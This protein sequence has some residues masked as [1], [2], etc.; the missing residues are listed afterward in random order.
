MPIA[1]AILLAAC[2]SPSEPSMNRADPAFL[3][4]YAATWRFQLGR[5][6]AITVSPDGATALFLRSGPRSFVQDLWELN[7]ATGVA[8]VRLTADALLGGAEETLTAEEL[9][10]RERMRST[11]RGIASY[12]LSRDGRTLVVPLSG[13]LYVVDRGTG[14]ARALPDPPGFPLDPRLSPDGARLACTI[15]HDLWV[16]TLA[17]GA[18]TRLTFTGSAT[19]DNGTAEFVAQEEMS[20]FQGFWWSPDSQRIAYES[21]D[22]ADVELLYIADP[23][24]PEKPAQPWRYPRAG[25]TNAT[26]RLGVVDAAGGPSS[27]VDWDRETYPYL[28]AVTWAEGAPLALLVQNRTQ[29]EERL[30]A[31]DDT[32]HTRLLLEE[33]DAAWVNLAPGMP[34]WLPDGSFLW[35][36]ERSGDWQLE[37]VSATG[38]R[39]PLPVPGLAGLVRI[40][41]D[42]REAIVVAS[43]EP[44]E[45]HLWA[46][47]LDGAAPR[48]LTTG[49][50]VHGAGASPGTDRLVDTVVDVDGTWTTR[51]LD[52]AGTALAEIPEVAEAP[53]FVPRIEL[54]SVTARELRAVV[55]RPRDFD[56]TKKYP[57]IVH[58][59]GGPHSQQVV[60]NA[61]AYLLQ[62]WY[63]DHGFVVVAID[64]RGTPARGRVWERAVKGNLIAVPLEDQ[65]A[66]LQALGER[67]PELDLGRVG[68]TGWSFGGYFSAMA[69]ARRPDVYH[70]AVAGAPVTDWANYDTHY[71]ERYMGLPAENP[72]GYADASVL[73]HAPTLSR[74]LL[75]VH[76]TADDNVYFLHSLE[77]AD[78]L[79]RAGRPFEL[80]PLPGFTHM[81]PDPVVTPRLYTRVIGFLDDA[82]TSTK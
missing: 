61:N 13:R 4:Q 11:S 39:A 44:T 71:T 25:R 16:V 26:V 52:A 78:V 70:A 80:L 50:A 36:T 81:V 65:V 24:H 28:A 15:A 42:R 79:F 35:M 53:P 63:A 18:W 75:I 82:L 37:H 12:E 68:I 17:T 21:S 59:Y 29:T 23:M 10:R 76:G 14:A 73:T 60:A 77:L 32:G 30:L 31:A 20:R 56:P 67:F 48:A 47:P 2:T 54:V 9:A 55:I 6:K 74:P 7:L 38:V 45:K 46:V 69:V 8:E 34:A 3:D 72:G 27:W 41:P 19:V 62:Q 33:S 49:R 1:L 58:V 66:G 51:V 57:V 40:D 43:G 5:P 64:G 22:V